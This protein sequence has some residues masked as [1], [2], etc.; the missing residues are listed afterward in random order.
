MLE[1]PVDKF[2]ARI[3]QN[4]GGRQRIARQQHLRLNVNQHRSHINEFRGDIHVEFTYALDVGEIL[5]RDPGDGNVVDVNVLLA[6]QVEQQVERP[7]IDFAERDSEWKVAGI[8][9][10]GPGS[11]GFALS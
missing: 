7:F 6:D 5:R 4:I 1:Q 10:R 2:I 11:G 9:F 8:V 3:F